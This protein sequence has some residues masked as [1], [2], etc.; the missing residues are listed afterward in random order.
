MNKLF[1]TFIT[2]VLR[3]RAPMGTEVRPQSQL[4]LGKDKKV[5]MRPDL[6]VDA[7]ARMVLVA[8][9]KYKGW[10]PTSSVTMTSTSCSPTARLQMWRG[11]C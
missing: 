7:G 9:C 4:F 1:E 3:E 5:E 10:S 11:D 6:M 2:E 8:D